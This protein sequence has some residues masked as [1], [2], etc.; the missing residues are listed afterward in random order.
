MATYQNLLDS[1]RVDTE[2]ATVE[3]DA[4]EALNQ[5]KGVIRRINGRGVLIDLS[6]TTILLADNTWKYGVPAGV[7]YVDRLA[8]E[9]DSGATSTFD[10]EIPRLHWRIILASAVPQFEFDTFLFDLRSGKDVRISGQGQATEPVA[11]T[12]T[13]PAQIVG[14]VEALW[15]TRILSRLSMGRSELSLDR[16]NQRR[17]AVTE[18]EAQFAS[19]PARVRPGSVR[20]LGR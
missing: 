19:A 11:L 20:V 18:E 4:A 2:A 12:D 6:D 8:Y 5:A 9:D 13:V 10:E 3:Y 17:E 7:V 14:L 15:R 16:A 1:L